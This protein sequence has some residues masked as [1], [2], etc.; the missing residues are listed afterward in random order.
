LLLAVVAHAFGL[1]TSVVPCWV[2]ALVGGGLNGANEWCVRRGYYVF[3]AAAIEIPLDHLFITY[4][5]IKTGGVQSPFL[6]LYVVQVLATA[7]LVDRLLAAASAVLAILLWLAAVSAQAAGYIEAPPLFLAG[8][9]AATGVYHGTWAAFLFY[10]LALLVYLGGY[11]SQRLRSSERNLEEEHR[12]LQAAL[13]SLR[14]AH[15]E[16]SAAYDRLK[17][18]E[19]HLV[20]S[21]KMRSLGQLVAGIA[22]ELNN[23]ISFVSA[24]VEH[25]RTYVNRLGQ[26]LAAYGEVSLPAEPRARIEAL[27]CQL[28]IDDVLA[29]CPA[30]LDDCEEGARRTKHIVSEL[31]AF[32]RSDEHEAWRLTDL[33]RGIESTLALLAH[34]LTD[35]IVVHRD[36]GDLPAVECLPGQLNQVF[37]N[38]FA[39]AADAIGNRRGN[40]WI[41][42][43]TLSSGAAGERAEQL[44]TIAIC[45]DGPGM[46]PEVRDRV[47]DPFFTTKEVGEG[48]GLGLSVSYAIV[49]RHHGRLS[50]AS[51][52]GAGAIF[53]ITLP[54]RQ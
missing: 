31:R 53:T 5:V 8:A 50:V 42:T 3:A 11:I 29:D 16:L 9:P 46:A 52:P 15:E 48:T 33:H 20:Q 2:A 23:P 44:V 6:V 40:I 35:R 18:T 37:M 10:C 45:D 32:S 17:Q 19:V 14:T 13:V 28:R 7:M 47:F 30:L 34:R 51:T 38:L 1:F 27:R 22:H 12:R 21:E 24:N 39:N 49:Q 26:A 54:L 43:R 4:L 25:L 41:S 36:F